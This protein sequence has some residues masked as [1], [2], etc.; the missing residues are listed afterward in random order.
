VK[1]E[2]GGKAAGGQSPVR[3]AGARE[4]G[5]DPAKFV[6]AIESATDSAIRRDR[7]ELI[8]EIEEQAKALVK[9]RTVGEMTRYRELIAGFMKTVVGESFQVTE[10]TSARFIE[11]NKVFIIARRIEEKLIEMAERIQAG[12]ADALAITAATSEIRGL[13]LDITA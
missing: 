2:R 1:V 6:E 9:R 4:K 7:D 12:T 8:R 3:Q 5:A 13:L 11:N 10:V